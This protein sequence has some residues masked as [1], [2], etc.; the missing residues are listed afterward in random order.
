MCNTKTQSESALFDFRE[1]LLRE[2]KLDG[3]TVDEHGSPFECLD[4]AYFI[5]E[6]NKLI[7][8]RNEIEVD[9]FHRRISN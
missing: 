8:I 7:S 2:I 3:Q 6:I 5:T 9:R 4:H 1:I